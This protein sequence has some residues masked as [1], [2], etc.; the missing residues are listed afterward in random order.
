MHTALHCKASSAPKG[1][2]EG[3]ISTPR[4]WARMLFQ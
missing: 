3:A 2:R 1:L 4:V